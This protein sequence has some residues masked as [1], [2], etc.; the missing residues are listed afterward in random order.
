MSVAGWEK[1]VLEAE[2]AVRIAHDG[3]VEAIAPAIELADLDGPVDDAEA[4]L[5]CGI[6]HRAVILGTF[7]E[8]EADGLQVEVLRNGAAVAGPADALVLIGHPRDVLSAIDADLA[9][10]DVVITGATVPPIPITPG[11]E[12]LVRFHDLGEVS[13]R[14]A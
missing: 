12:F 8:R 2:I 4:I 11:D 6:F 1:P 5:A 10:G 14:C 7:V 3:R 9:P 13:I